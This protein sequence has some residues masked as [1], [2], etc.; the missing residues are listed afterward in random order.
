VRIDNH[1]NFITVAE[2]KE[3]IDWVYDNLETFKPGHSR[4]QSRGV[5]EYRITTRMVKTDIKYSN[6]FFTIQ[7]R[8]SELYK[9]PISLKEDLGMDKGFI[10]VI[11][12]PGGYT[13]AHT[14]AIKNTNH[15]VRF[16]I[17]VQPPDAG[18]ILTVGERVVS[19]EACELHCYTATR[20]EHSVT[21]VK[22]DTDRVIIIFGFE[23]GDDWEKEVN[24][25]TNTILEEIKE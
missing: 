17:V 4:S 3:V 6:I 11:T 15:C 20:W 9:I 10:T 22:G 21:E 19:T 24:D 2:S 23:I 13:R 12:K 5:Y 18:A 25:F 7:N 14:D 8:I 16:N 1:K